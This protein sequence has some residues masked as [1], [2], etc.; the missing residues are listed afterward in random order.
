MV[1]DGIDA[2]VRSA[3]ALGL[4]LSSA[5]WDRLREMRGLWAGY[6]RSMNLVGPGQLEEQM[7]ESLML[8]AAV[9]RVGLA[10]T[11]LWVDVGSG[12]GFPGLVFVAC[13][14]GRGLL[15][16]PR[17]KRSSFLELALRR[18]GADGWAVVRGRLEADG[19]HLVEGGTFP[20]ADS[21]MPVRGAS[22]RAVW[23][24]EAW[25]RRAAGVLL[26]GDD[27]V[28]SV[29]VHREAP[30]VDGLEAAVVVDHHGWSV[31]LYRLGDV[32]RRFT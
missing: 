32:R 6:A 12:G 25:L 17:E 23:G 10:R 13:E 5:N 18:M 14:G 9:R 8:V 30:A 4:E 11:G 19:V 2:L 7:S 22:A 15:I 31:R 1:S 29:H 20:L 28:V 26:G 21:Q 27:C 16:E 3:D 24:P